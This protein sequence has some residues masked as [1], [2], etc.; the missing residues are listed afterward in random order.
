MIYGFILGSE[1][2][3][4]IIWNSQNNLVFAETLFEADWDYNVVILDT[5]LKY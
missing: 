5:H 3:E 4:V 2:I 1:F